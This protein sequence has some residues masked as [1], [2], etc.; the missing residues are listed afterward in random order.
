MASVGSRAV[1]AAVRSGVRPSGAAHAPAAVAAPPRRSGWRPHRSRPARPSD[2]AAG[3]R[4]RTVL[5]RDPA[6]AV[7]A[8]VRRDAAARRAAPTSPG[9]ARRASD[10]PQPRLVCGRTQR[11]PRAHR[12]DRADRASDWR[13]AVR[14]PADPPSSR[15][16]FAQLND[17]RIVGPDRVETPARS[18]RNASARTC[19]SRS[20]SFAPAAV[21][22]SRKRSSCFGLSAKTLKPCSIKVST[23]TPAR[24]LDAHGNRRRRRARLLADPLHRLVHGR[25][26]Y[27]PPAA[28]AADRVP[29]AS[30]RQNSCASLPQSMPRNH[31]NV[32]DTRCSFLTRPCRE[33]HHPCTGARGATSHWMSLT[34]HPV[35]AQVSAWRSRRRHGWHSR[36]GGR[37][38]SSSYCGSHAS[39][40]AAGA[41]DAQNASTAPW[42][43]NGE[44]RRQAPGS[45][46]AVSVRLKPDTTSLTPAG[47]RRDLEDQPRRRVR[48]RARSQRPC[49]AR[50]SRAP[51]G[52]SPLRSH[53]PY[54]AGSPSS[55]ARAA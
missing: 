5:G 37:A 47:A 35:E 17:Q 50:R 22:R 40:E 25:R 54:R 43:T 46:N 6:N 52:S 11:Q 51:S 34:V 55:P 53:Q 20:S 30:S 33:L 10:R 27:A 13:G 2:A 26:R 23:N 8:Q 3:V 45:V 41:V 24:R 18:V 1:P 38:R 31:S 36:R 49:G 28:L 9:R 12:R 32:S 48:S 4:V 42:K 44:T 14:P 16:H 21:N 19:A 15:H 39:V 7:G 29:L